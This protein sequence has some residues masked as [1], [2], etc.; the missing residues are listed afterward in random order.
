MHNS[1][2]KFFLFQAGA[3]IVSMI[4]AIF[5]IRVLGSTEYGF[6]SFYLVIADFLKTSVLLGLDQSVTHL[7][8]R[9]KNIDVHNIA[10]FNSKLFVFLILLPFLFFAQD[11][12]V[13]VSLLIFM[14]AALIDFSYLHMEKSNLEALAKVTFFSRTLFFL[15]I[16]ILG[17]SNLPYQFFFLG[18]SVAILIFSIC[19]L[20]LNNQ[21]KSIK[22][23]L[24]AGFRLL[25]EVASVGLSKIFLLLEVLIVLFIFKQNMTYQIF[26]YFMI[27]YNFTKAL[28]GLLSISITPVYKRVTLNNDSLNQ[29]L[30]LLCALG[31]CF[32]ILG[33]LA[34]YVLPAAF[35]KSIIKLD[36]NED[37]LKLWLA[38]GIFYSFVIFFSSIY[39]NVVLIAFKK[40]RSFYYSRFLYITLAIILISLSHIKTPTMPIIILI[41]SESVILI[42]ALLSGFRKM[43][44]DINIP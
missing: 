11:N 10:I 25:P 43:P 23:D 5:L 24:S 28:S 17:K 37:L 3:L 34:D 41:V 2:N 22:F 32:L 6:F 26:G 42:L 1:I 13:R 36:V 39:I 15:I 18:F 21:L 27:L 4:T 8:S 35:V 20:F 40:L 30:R 7:K 14:F 31:F 38:W 16:I 9:E 12:Y 44:S 33:L 19:I 29:S